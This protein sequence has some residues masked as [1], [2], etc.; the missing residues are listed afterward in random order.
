[1]KG[2][3]AEFRVEDSGGGIAGERLPTLFETFTS[4][5]PGGLG[6]GLAISRTIVEAHGGRLS[7]GNRAGGGAEFRVT[8]PLA[9]AS[10]VEFPASSERRSG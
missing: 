6:I 1:M 8:L 5:K 4:T 7:A 2:G 10:V 9:S 3:T